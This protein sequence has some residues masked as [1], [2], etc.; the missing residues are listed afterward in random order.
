MQN[1][2]LE[3]KALE[4]RLRRMPPAGSGLVFLPL[5]AG[6]RSPGFAV[7][8]SGAIAG[9]TLATNGDDIARAGLEGIAIDFAR[10][11][12]S[13]DRTAPGAGALVASG[14]GLLASPAWMQIMADAIGKPVVAGQAREAS[15]RGAAILVLEHLGRRRGQQKQEVPRGRTFRPREEAHRAYLAAAA[16][17]ERLYR[18]LVVDRLVDAGAPAHVN[19]G[20]RPP[21]AG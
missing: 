15:S 16:R 5:L 1:L 10:V 3:E 4:R 13:L 14:A 11:D 21:E 17:Q 8:A 20:G 18:A 12:R 19:V 2:R 9:L 7:R 6:E